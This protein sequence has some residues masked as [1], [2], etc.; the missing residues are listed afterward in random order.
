MQRGKNRIEGPEEGEKEKT[1]VH[2]PILQCDTGALT[3]FISAVRDPPS[4]RQKIICQEPVSVVDGTGTL[5]LDRHSCRTVAVRISSRYS[6][7]KSIWMSLSTFY[8]L[9][10]VPSHSQKIPQ[11]HT[12]K[13]SGLRA[14]TESGTDDAGCHGRK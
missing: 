10:D 14:T 1:G 4:P 9:Y 5:R 7:G 6:G 13:E 2:I 11:F 8:S 3:Q 12:E